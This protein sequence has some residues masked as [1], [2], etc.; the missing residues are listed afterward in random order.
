M[1]I[2]FRRASTIVVSYP[3]LGSL[4]L[5]LWECAHVTSSVAEESLLEISLIKTI[6]DIPIIHASSETN[7]ALAGILSEV[8][9]RLSQKVLIFLATVAK[10]A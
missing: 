5:E 1:R 7:G 6:F 9:I 4:I 8:C 2:V 10:P 3:E